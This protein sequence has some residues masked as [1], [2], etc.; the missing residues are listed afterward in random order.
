VL[1]VAGRDMADNFVAEEPLSH[2]PDGRSLTIE[3][4]RFGHV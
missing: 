2:G 3:R 4:W 1:D